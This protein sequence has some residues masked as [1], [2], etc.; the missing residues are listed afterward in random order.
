MENTSGH[1]LVRSR[2]VLCN[3]SDAESPDVRTRLLSCELNKGD[4]DDAV[5]ASTPPLE[6]KRIP[7]SRYTSEREKR[8]KPLRDKCKDILGYIF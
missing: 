8:G 3:N 7:F 6:R 1:I 4:R 5:S 2:W